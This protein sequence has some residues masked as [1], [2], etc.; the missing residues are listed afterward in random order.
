VQSDS[1]S[2]KSTRK[3]KVDIFPENSRPESKINQNHPSLAFIGLDIENAEK[4][5]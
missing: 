4:K 5:N 1:L 3:E 2:T